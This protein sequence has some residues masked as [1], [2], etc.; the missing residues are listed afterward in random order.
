MR[1]KTSAEGE[2][3]SFGY[4][5]AINA[6]HIIVAGH[7]C[8]FTVARLLYL[9]RKNKSDL[10]GTTIFLNT[11]GG[12][13]ASALEIYSMIKAAGNIT[14]HAFGVCQSA[15]TIILQGA[16]TRLASSSCRFMVHYGDESAA[17]K[18][19]EKDNNRMYKSMRQIYKEH[20]NVSPQAIGA[21]FSKNTYMDSE[22]AKRVGLIDEIKE[23]L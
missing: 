15:G 21:W 12:D 6:G 8:E 4:V 11:Y 1:F 2:D 7:I 14:V 9:L 10:H 20:V 17:S 22:H 13:L 16:V 18:E 23:V 19:D 3:L 5:E